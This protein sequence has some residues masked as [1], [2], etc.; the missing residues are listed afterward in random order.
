MNWNFKPIASIVSGGLL[1]ATT[2]CTTDPQSPG[3]EYMPDMYRS[4]AV[5]AYV[6][7]DHIDKLSARRP[8]PGTIPYSADS[9]T[10]M[11]SLP[12]SYPKTTEGY[13]AA[14][15][16]LLSPLP[17][18]KEYIEEGKVL[19]TKFCMHCHG[20][21]GLGDGAVVTNGGYPPPPAYNGT[22]LKGLLEGKMFHTI[23]YGKGAMGPHN[24]QL[25]KLERWKVIQ[26][27]KVLQ[28]DGKSPFDAATPAPAADSTQA[29]I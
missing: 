13:E 12:Y 19:F 21:K 5:E 20:E 7:Y 18:T 4:H 1:L 29:K 9:L 11:N 25:T 15:A 17:T 8:V 2:A 16:S 14:G 27:V 6:D 26:Y 23:T 10:M 22:Q 24:S 3:V 28:N